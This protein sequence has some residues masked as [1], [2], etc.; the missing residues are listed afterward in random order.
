[1][2]SA[3]AIRNQGVTYFA[4]SA[5]DIFCQ[6]VFVCAIN[7]SIVTCFCAVFL[8]ILVIMFVWFA[9]FMA[10]APFVAS[11]GIGP[12][13]DDLRALAGRADAVANIFL[14]SAQRA[15][16]VID[17]VDVLDSFDAAALQK[18]QATAFQQD[19]QRLDDLMS[20]G[21][22]CP[23]C[24]REYSRLCP[25]SWDESGVGVCAASPVYDGA[26]PAY[27]NFS[28][29]SA[30][31][32]QKFERRCSVCWPCV[33][34]GAG[35]SRG[36]RALSRGV[37]AAGFLRPAR[38]DAVQVATVHLVEPDNEVSNAAHDLGLAVADAFQAVEARQR[39]DES[40]YSSLLASS[41][42]LPHASGATES[43]TTQ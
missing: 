1:M 15:P 25:E 41:G 38:T 26:C 31:D 10:V 2:S 16:S 11:Y 17:S 35:P 4:A 42:A 5:W 30:A 8:R 40:A 43:R 32:K 28:S 39:A 7:S 18:L 34:R 24:V 19:R 12:T 33:S 23:L 13:I 20:A 36:A 29:M 6:G 37:A 14:E 9:R 22:R 3:H 27:D 21:G